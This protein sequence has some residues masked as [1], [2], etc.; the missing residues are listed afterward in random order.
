[1]PAPAL[2]SDRTHGEHIFQGRVL[3]EAGTVSQSL[4]AMKLLSNK[5]AGSVVSSQRDLIDQQ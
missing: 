4:S 1:M 2:A 3:N 5:N